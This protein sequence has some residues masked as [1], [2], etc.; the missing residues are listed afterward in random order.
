MCEAEAKGPSPGQ[1]LGDSG[2]KFENQKDEARRR[3]SCTHTVSHNFI[4]LIILAS[5]RGK[6]EREE[7]IN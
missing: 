2:Q 1:A 6:I 5:W 7:K 4:H 3:R